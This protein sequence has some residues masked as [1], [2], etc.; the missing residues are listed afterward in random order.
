MTIPSALKRLGLLGPLAAGIIL[1]SACSLEITQ[2]PGGTT[3]LAQTPPPSLNASPTPVLAIHTPTVAGP[4]EPAPTPSPESPTEPILPI[5]VLPSAV[6]LG[7]SGR[8]LFLTLLAGNGQAWAALDFSTGELS[9]LFINPPNSW[10]LSQSVHADG[11]TAVIAYAPPPP[12]GQPQYGYTDL[13]LI[14]PDDPS[15][16]RPLLTRT[17][18]FEAFFDAFFSPDG[19]YVYYTHFFEDSSDG[20]RF[21][22]FVRRLALPDGPSEVVVEDAFYQRLSPDGTKLAYVTFNRPDLVFDELYVAEPDG[23]NPIRVLN[24]DEFP[25]VDA[26]FF[27]PDAEYLYFSAVVETTPSLSWWQE[28]LGMRI[29]RAHDVPSDFWRIHFPTGEVQRVTE[30]FDRGMNGVFSADGE[31]IAFLSATGAFVMR[32]D[33]SELTPILTSAS[34]YGVPAWIP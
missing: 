9:T 19:N 6:E 31:W 22:Y 4:G 13:F 20:N 2:T 17:V 27:S 24:P 8:L 29:A 16:L 14:S 28:L 3:P 11:T 21:R 33:G 7:L 30:L 18:E 25:T 23:R 32:P 26:P 12:E 34:L 10:L 15:N 1:S 5:E